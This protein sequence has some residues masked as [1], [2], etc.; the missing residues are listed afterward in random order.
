MLY[1]HGVASA[2][3][4]QQHIRA[5]CHA[6]DRQAAAGAGLLQLATLGPESYPDW[7]LVT[8][9]LPVCHGGLRLPRRATQR[10]WHS[11]KAL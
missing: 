8:A 11:C 10:L 6:V 4:A 3:Q 5:A 9:R 1:I 7:P 2:A